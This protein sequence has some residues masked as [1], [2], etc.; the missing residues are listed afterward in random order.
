MVQTAS[1]RPIGSSPPLH[2]SPRFPDSDRS[3]GL[4][5][6]PP[7][8]PVANRRHSLKTIEAARM[9]QTAEGRRRIPWCQELRTWCILVEAEADLEPGIGSLPLSW[10]WHFGQIG[11]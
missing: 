11:G 3:Y 2:F 8:A 4:H 10:H 1:A 7:A 6:A 9:S 5:F